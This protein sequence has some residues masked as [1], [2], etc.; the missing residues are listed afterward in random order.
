MNVVDGFQTRRVFEVRAFVRDCFDGHGVRYL[1]GSVGSFEYDRLWGLNCAL[2]AAA[3]R[4]PVAVCEYGAAGPIGG[5][6]RRY[7]TAVE[8]DGN[9]YS[10]LEYMKMLGDPY[11]Q[12]PPL[13][14]RPKG[15]NWGGILKKVEIP[16]TKG[17]LKRI[18]SLRPD[19]RREGFI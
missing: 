15:D 7:G 1:F 2:W 6:Y 17:P 11:P 14:D 13:H 16:W 19:R 3:P 9:R 18:S 12:L 10:P 8:E 4:P 5:V